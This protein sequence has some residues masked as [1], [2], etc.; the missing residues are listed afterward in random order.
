MDLS[1]G[2][3]PGIEDQMTLRDLL[4]AGFDLD[5]Q[6]V[7][8]Q[9]DEDGDDYVYGVALPHNQPQVVTI[10][11]DGHA[12]SQFQAILLVPDGDT[13]YGVIVHD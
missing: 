3:K 5:T 11:I 7:A 8:K 6:I 12:D 4:D 2:R 10:D 13:L 9:N 1:A